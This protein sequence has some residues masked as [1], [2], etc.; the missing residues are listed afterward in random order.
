M[1][2]VG[3]LIDFL[4]FMYRY[5]FYCKTDVVSSYSSYKLQRRPRFINDVPRSCFSSFFGGLEGVGL[6]FAYVAHFVFFE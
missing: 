1:T 5:L 4:K 2:V 6:S 3:W